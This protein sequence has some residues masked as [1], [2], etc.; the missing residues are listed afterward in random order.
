MKPWILVLALPLLAAEWP[1]WRGPGRD[2]ISQETGLLKSWSVDGPPLVWKA[3]GLGEGYSAFSVSQ[4]LLFTQGQRGGQEFVLAIDIKTGKRV[5]GTPTGESYHEQRGNGPR[6]TPT[7]DGDRL[8]AEAAD[9][10]LVCL[11]QR[12]G[13]QVWTVN[14]PKRFNAD[15]PHWAYS[16]SPL[17]DGERLIVTPGG[18]GAAV[19]ALD[20][21]TGATV[22][23]ALSDRAG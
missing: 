7:L 5:W 20:K 10:T 16:E 23:K 4:G 19:V 14:L 6:G 11:E 21:K 17:V 2:G 8:Y 3:K 15:R 13:K 18:R 1:Q 12:T 9:G 22:W